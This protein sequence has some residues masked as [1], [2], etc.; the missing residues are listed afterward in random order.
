MSRSVLW[1]AVAG[2]LSDVNSTFIN[3]AKVIIP[4][5]IAVE[6]L[7]RFGVIEKIAP[8][9]QPLMM[10]FDLP[11]EMGLVWLTGL[12]TS[13]WGA[14]A[15]LF[16]VVPADTLTVADLTVFS[17]LLL[18]AHA[19]PL[20]QA[21]IRS[22][23]PSFILTALLRI[24]G[25]MLFAATLRMIFDAT[26]WLSGPI[27]PTL[28]SEMTSASATGFWLGL[29]K[30]LRKMYAVLALLIACMHLLEKTGTTRLFQRLAAPP[31]RL[32]GLKSEAV[33]V[34]SVGLII[35]IAF[36]GGLLKRAAGRDRISS[37]QLLL[38]CVF[39]GF[40]HAIIEDTLLMVALGAD[41][42]TV[43]FGRLVFAILATGIIALGLNLLAN[44]GRLKKSG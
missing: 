5:S 17:G 29:V 19:L 1:R 11:A 35:G 36:G 15:I 32:A 30:M 4:V 27:Q 10:V 33:E 2:W 16:A 25:A 40:A 43:F 28:S 26:G 34:T 22:V 23:G 39:L 42:T 21:V 41:F 31:L 18:V 14:A 8:F 7:S 24:A 9:L 12:L 44:G 13:I 20:E 38:S 6:G 3:L 37:R